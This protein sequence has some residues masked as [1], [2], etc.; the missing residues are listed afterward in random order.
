MRGCS[1]KATRWLSRV[2]EEDAPFWA[3]ERLGLVRQAFPSPRTARTWQNARLRVAGTVEPDTADKSGRAGHW[4]RLSSR[5][6]A[7]TRLRRRCLEPALRD[8]PVLP[9]RPS[10]QANAPPRRHTRPQTTI[11]FIKRGARMIRNA[12]SRRVTDWPS[13]QADIGRSV[14]LRRPWIASPRTRAADV[15]EGQS[16]R[17]TSD[18]ARARH[19]LRHDCSATVRVRRKDDLYDDT[20]AVKV[21]ARQ[22]VA[23]SKIF[24]EDYARI[25]ASKAAQGGPDADDCEGWNHGDVSNADPPEEAKHHNS[26]HRSFAAAARSFTHSLPLGSVPQNKQPDDLYGL[27]VFGLTRDDDAEFLPLVHLWFEL[28]EHLTADSI[29]DPMEFFQEQEAIANI[30]RAARWRN[31]HARLPSRNGEL[32]LDSDTS[33]EEDGDGSAWSEDSGA[34]P[35]SEALSI[36]RRK[37]DLSRSTSDA[38]L[39]FGRTSCSPREGSSLVDLHAAKLVRS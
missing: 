25:D 16:Q 34:H 26:I 1:M 20:A 8:V 11:S 18:G 30:I 10:T 17:S 36:E 31:P 38:N 33:D 13:N 39:R 12:G 28:T 6:L 3:Q 37:G 5:L 21:N 24:F 7:S 23:M 2:Q 14:D 22:H 29:T 15:E 19:Y 9:A 35:H 32:E 4:D 27:D